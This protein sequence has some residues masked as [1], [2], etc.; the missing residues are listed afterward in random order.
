MAAFREIV[1]D[2]AGLGGGIDISRL[3]D[4]KTE[5]FMQRGPLQSGYPVLKLF[6]PFTQEKSPRVPKFLSQRFSPIVAG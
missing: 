4:R 1:R 2:Q 6:L 5:I 3:S